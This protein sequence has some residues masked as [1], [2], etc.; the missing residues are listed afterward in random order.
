MLGEGRAVRCEV[1][2]RGRIAIGFDNRVGRLALAVEP[3]SELV[4]AA[5]ADEAGRRA[6]FLLQLVDE[7][8]HGRRQLGQRLD[9]A[10][11]SHLPCHRPHF[12]GGETDQ[13]QNWQ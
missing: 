12:C 7:V 4:A 8:A 9:L 1:E 13:T 11:G 3:R 5:T 2:G 10:G 6:T